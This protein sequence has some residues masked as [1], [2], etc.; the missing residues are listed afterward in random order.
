MILELLTKK[1]TF[2]V[3]TILLVS[4]GFI[5]QYY[6]QFY[7][8]YIFVQQQ[9]IVITSLVT[10]AVLFVV[11]FLLFQFKSIPSLLKN[12]WL[13]LASALFFS[14]ITPLI[15]Y[16]INGFY[17]WIS[18]GSIN[19]NAFLCIII[20]L[21]AFLAIR[22]KE[23]KKGYDNNMSYY[24][25]W[26]LL[27]VVLLMSVIN[28]NFLST[29]SILLLII[30]GS[31]LSG[32]KRLESIFFFLAL[33]VYALMIF[34]SGESYNKIKSFYTHDDIDGKSYQIV[35]C[36]NSFDYG[37]LTGIGFQKT[38]RTLNDKNI[39]PGP[40]N[41]S[42]FAVVIEQFGI[43]GSIFVLILFFI[44]LFGIHKASV[45]SEDENAAVFLKLSLFILVFFN[46]IHILSCLNILP[47]H[48]NLS[49]FSWEKSL[50]LY[51]VAIAGLS[52]RI[53]NKKMQIKL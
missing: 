23:L 41:H 31:F 30:I 36:L 17:G 13:W 5:I 18:I 48:S 1:S 22:I 25:E 21:S 35:Q 7:W 52:F 40:T 14:I 49:F 16:K 32:K 46:S 4:F 9:K 37:G 19:I 50:N 15:G 3:T 51:T 8:F 20:S 28:L 10:Q 33:V 12:R 11:I 42:S 39:L 45:K 38:K 29:I 47:L 6:E 24:I 44:F 26:A 34:N 53:L 2:L 27:I 43:I